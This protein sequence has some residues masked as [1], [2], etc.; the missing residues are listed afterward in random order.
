M[1]STQIKSVGEYRFTSDKNLAIKPVPLGID[2]EAEFQTT[3][4][5][6]FVKQGFT[7]LPDTPL[8]KMIQNEILVSEKEADNA[9]DKVIEIRGENYLQ[10]SYH[11]PLV[12]ERNVTGKGK[13]GSICINENDCLKFSESMT[14]MNNN[15]ETRTVNDFLKLDSSEPVLQSKHTTY[16]DK[17]FGESDNQNIKIIKKVDPE[18]R[19]DNAKPLPGEAYAIVRKRI[20]PGN[21]DYH[22]AY[23][24]YMHQ[25]INI[26]LEAEAD[27]GIYYL[28]KFCFYDVNPNNYTFYKRWSG[29]IYPKDDIRHDAL[30]GNSITIVLEARPW[31]DVEGTLMSEIEADKTRRSKTAKVAKSRKSG[32]EKNSTGKSSTGKSSAGKPKKGGKMKRKSIKLYSVKK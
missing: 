32:T 15:I 8:Y 3:S 24:V 1:T 4:D 23:V 7:I 5:F 16:A 29:L 11:R 18:Y 10:Y 21:Q 6:L 13:S 12:D 22:I 19:N 20:I 25:D 30:Y 2:Y 14:M 26:T 31:Q 28:P 27:D 9:T 17:V